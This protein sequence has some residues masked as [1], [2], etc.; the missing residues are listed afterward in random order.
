MAVELLNMKSFAKQL[1]N[2]TFT[3]YY[4]RLSLLARSVFKWEGLPAGIEESFIEKFLFNY[5]EC[6]FY[7]DKTKGLFVTQCTPN[8][9]LNNFEEPVSVTPSGIDVD[10]VSLTIDKDCVLIKNN[11]MRYP[12]SY[13]V[14]LFAYRLAEIS[15][16]IDINVNA[17]KTPVLIMGSEKQRLTLKNVYAQWNGFEPVIFGDKSLTEEPMT[18]LKTDAPIV[19]PQLQEQ[20]QNIWNECLTFLG[21]NNANTDKR[22]RL[23][24]DEVQANNTHIDLSAD[25]FFKS[26][27]MAA[28]KINKLFN[29]EIKVTL[30][31]DIHLCTQLTQNTSET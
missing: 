1:N 26:R 18:T 29:T 8:D 19:F 3:D 4:A 22:E 17:Q 23:I 12:T 2:M 10:P 14:K 7:K 24:S 5:G 13:F 25:C 11:D 20:K 6:V 16:T 15:R 28:E 30:R 31:E 27:Q 9:K 21:I